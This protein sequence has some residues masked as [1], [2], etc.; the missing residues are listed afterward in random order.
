M[1]ACQPVWPAP[2]SRTSKSTQYHVAML[3]TS[4]LLWMWD[5]PLARDQFSF[6]MF[7][8]AWIWSP[9]DQYPRQNKQER[10]YENAPAIW[11]FAGC[12]LPSRY[13]TVQHNAEVEIVQ[14]IVLQDW[15]S[16]DIIV[17]LSWDGA[18]VHSSPL[19]LC[20]MQQLIWDSESFK[21]KSPLSLIDTWR[22]TVTRSIWDVAWDSWV[23]AKHETEA[24]VALALVFALYCE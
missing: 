5:H 11:Q 16:K 9:G 24:Y 18:H 7:R 6:C 8:Q 19:L 23:A 4:E 17:F 10:I 12:N 14:K 3:V 2:V 13:Y 1:A 15:H 20:E 21:L 22:D